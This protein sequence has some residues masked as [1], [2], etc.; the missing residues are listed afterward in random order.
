[1]T[2]IVSAQSLIVSFESARPVSFF[3][4]LAHCRILAKLARAANQNNQSSPVG[5]VRDVAQPGSGDSVIATPSGGAAQI[6]GDEI[7]RLCGGGLY[8]QALSLTQEALGEAA[9]PAEVRALQATEGAVRERAVVA[10][11]SAAPS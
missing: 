11:A 3:L 7:E 2:V 5:D 6:A 9:N 8:A 1:M 4:E 10:R